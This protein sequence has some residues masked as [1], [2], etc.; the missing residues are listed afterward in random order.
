M[1]SPAQSAILTLLLS[2]TVVNTET[3][4]RSIVDA[5]NDISLSQAGSSY[6]S[7]LEIVYCGVTFQLTMNPI[8]PEMSGLKKI[9]CNLDP[10][11]VLSIIDIR[12]GDHIAGGERVPAIIQAL[13]DVA[14]KLGTLLGAKGTIWHPANIVSGFPYFS[15]VVADYLNGGHFPALALVNFKREDDG[16][17]TSTGLALLSG[18]ELQ[19][20]QSEMDQT[21]IM[22]R[23]V[24]VVHDIATNGPVRDAVKLA[25]IECGE[26][27]ELEPLSDSGFLKMNAYSHPAA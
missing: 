24:R 9:F 6:G 10:S 22:R 4:L 18:Q 7:A 19:V 23:V 20:R 27:V 16:V 11:S 1:S 8:L 21:E 13:L 15:E 5:G 2:D 12:L 17:I 3:A 26:I 14:Q 25:G